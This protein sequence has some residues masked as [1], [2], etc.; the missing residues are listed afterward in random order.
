MVFARGDDIQNNAR[1]HPPIALV[2]DVAQAYSV[3]RKKIAR[4]KVRI[5]HAERVMP[6]LSPN[7]KG[8]NLM[9]KPVRTILLVG[10]AVCGLSVSSFAQMSVNPST[11]SYGAFNGPPFWAQE[12][13]QSCAQPAPP[14]PATQQSPITI[15]GTFTQISDQI[16]FNYNSPPSGQSE[17]VVY[18]NYA[19]EVEAQNGQTMNSTVTYENDTYTLQNVHFHFPAEHATPEI[20]SGQAVVEVH[21]V[22]KDA[23]GNVLVIA[24]LGKIGNTNGTIGTIWGSLPSSYGG[25]G[26]VSINPIKLTPDEGAGDTTKLNYYKY[27]G[28]LT[29]PPCTGGVTWLVLKRYIQVSQAQLNNTIQCNTFKYLPGPPPLSGCQNARPAQTLLSGTTISDTSFPQ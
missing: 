16:T 8:R 9:L 22:N 1:N 26:A 14:A 15:A 3:G 20:P 24:I 17:Y 23:S 6:D 13:P 29:V 28:S 21:F 5:R 4:L 18:N 11:W 7:Q 10:F 2:F 25:H 12:I 19:V 27:K